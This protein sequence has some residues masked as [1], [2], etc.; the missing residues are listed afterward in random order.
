MGGRESG[1]FRVCDVANDNIIV[2]YRSV[3]VFPGFTIPFCQLRRRASPLD[4]TVLERV[5]GKR[6]TIERGPTQYT[7][8]TNRKLRADFET[9]GRDSGAP[10][11]RG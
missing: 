8:S 10:R 6:R 4:S 5:E 9:P 2:L 3:A 11:N 7:N 1:R